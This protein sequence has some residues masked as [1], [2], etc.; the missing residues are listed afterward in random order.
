LRGPEIESKTQRGT[1]RI[2]V[3]GDSFTFGENA[4]DE[5][6][7]TTQLEKRLNQNLSTT[8]FQVVN[9]GV[10]GY[11]NAQELLL[12][13][14][15][16]RHGIAADI[17]VLN[18]FTNDILDNLGLDYGSLSQNLVQPRFALTSSGK[19]ILEHKPQNT[20]ITGSNL[21]AVHHGSRSRLYSVTRANLESLLQAKPGLLKFAKKLGFTVSLPRA[22]GVLNAWYDDKVLEAGV[23]LMKELVREIDAEVRSLGGT[24]LVCLIPSPLQVYPETYGPILKGSLPDNPM[25]KRFLVDPNRPDRIVR[26]MCQDLGIPLL[27][28]YGYL[29]E[30]NEQSFYLPADGHFNNAGH[31]AFAISLE[32]F[33]RDHLPPNDPPHGSK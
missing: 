1:K 27:E 24:L 22:P 16:A 26:Q 19:L 32:K 9:A 11:G 3:L 28:L 33:V 14:R 12:V 31:T 25:V 20:L 2:I 13:R 7:F 5:V 17:Y 6:L 10:P 30:N 21:Q 23:P 15:L 4:P 29:A 18:V 8:K